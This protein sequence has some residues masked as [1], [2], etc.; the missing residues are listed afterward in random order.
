MPRIKCRHCKLPVDV[1]DDEEGFSCPKCGRYTPAHEPP[2]P[3]DLPPPQ[4]E[5]FSRRD[6]PESEPS[7]NF[8]AACT[9]VIAV[10]MVLLGGCLAV[11]AAFAADR[12]DTAI[13]RLGLACFCVLV[14]RMFQAAAYRQWH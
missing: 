3:P 8:F 5:V 2:P 1:G 7:G 14:A 9:L 12:W 6:E 13:F 4:S 10:V 11:S